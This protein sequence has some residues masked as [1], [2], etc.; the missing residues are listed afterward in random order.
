MEPNLAFHRALTATAADI[1]AALLRSQTV[2]DTDI[3]LMLNW[4]GEV[5]CNIVN[6]GDIEVLAEREDKHLFVAEAFEA[7]T[8]GGRN[9]LTGAR[10]ENISPAAATELQMDVMAKGVAIVAV[11]A[12][13][14]AANQGDA[15]RISPGT[16]QAKPEI[17]L[18]RL[19]QIGSADQRESRP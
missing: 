13:G 6:T 19:P 10:V 1:V 15:F 14:I 5:H 9:P 16:R 7:A 12:S 8:I 18:H 3:S 2:S 11:N 17:G 4:T